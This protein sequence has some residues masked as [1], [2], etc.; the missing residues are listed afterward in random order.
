MC[1]YRRHPWRQLPIYALAQTI[2]AF[3]AA[4][5]VY[6]TYVPAIHALSPPSPSTTVGIFATS[7]APFMNTAHAFLDEFVGSAILIF[8][9]FALTSKTYGVGM[10]FPLALGGVFV[11]ISSAFG[12]QTGFA[13]N[14]ARDFGPRVLVWVVG[15]GRDVWS[16]NGYYFWVSLFVLVGLVCR[17]C[18]NMCGL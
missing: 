13:I 2:G 17:V 15:Y 16:G 12:W 6:A 3:L 7:P 14:P 10:M 18:A 4:G 5:L 8:C 1:I 9:V 11:G